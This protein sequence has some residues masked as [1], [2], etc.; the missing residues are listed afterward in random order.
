[1]TPAITTRQLSK[2]FGRVTAL[3]RVS[4]SIP[5]NTICGLLGRN[6]A[7]KTTLLQILTGQGYASS[8]EVEVFGGNPFENERVLQRVS[9][10][11]ESQKYPDYFKVS[12]ALAAARIAF[13]LWD[14]DF[15]RS[16]VADFQ[17]PMSRRVK[18]LSRGMFSALGIVMALAS[19]APLTLFDEAHIGLDANAR[20]IFYDRLLADYASH[21]RTVVLSTHL[22]D[23]VSELVEHVLV[24]DRGRL[25]VDEE[26]ETLRGMAVTVTGPA[27]AVA[28]L[29]A[30]H[31]ELHRDRLGQLTRTTIIG[32]LSP[33]EQR[34]AASL[35]LD[36]A[37]L[38]LQQLVV[39]LTNQQA[40]LGD[41]ST[42]SGS[43][44][45]DLTAQGSTAQN[46]SAESGTAKEASR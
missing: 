42:A 32:P 43:T 24:L 33:A 11:K 8:G 38:S 28:D 7:G 23:E 41:T 26:A 17:L 19:R 10:A 45:E 6:G 5:E 37:G 14:G 39:R 35:R 36:I 20:Q 1:M 30:R 34:H 9:F 46:G 40:S 13:P 18:K 15:A 29:T 12:H 4:F 44:A 22:I 31:K 16:L 27:G 25:M 21:P 3:D 2:R